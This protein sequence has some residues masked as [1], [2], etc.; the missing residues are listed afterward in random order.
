MERRHDIHM[1]YAGKSP[2]LGSPWPYLMHKRHKD[3]PAEHAGPTSVPEGREQEDNTE[4]H[5]CALHDTAY[6]P[7]FLTLPASNLLACLRHAG[8]LLPSHRTFLSDVVLWQAAQRSAFQQM[9]IGSISG[10]STH[11]F[12]CHTKLYTYDAAQRE[13]SNAVSPLA[14][15]KAMECASMDTHRYGRIEERT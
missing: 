9:H 11:L 15:I 6:A 10:C 13:E 4:V 7:A 14:S 3:L 2:L 1:F 8:L 5:P 12:T